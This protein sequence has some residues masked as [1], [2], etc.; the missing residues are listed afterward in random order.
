MAKR[1]QKHGEHENS[2]RWLLTY[3]DMITLLMAFFIMLYSM[4]QLDLRKFAAVAGSVRAEL[5]GTGVME[6]GQGVG[7]GSG[8]GIDMGM[9]GIAP[10]LGP[11]PATALKTSVAA[12]MK[13]IAASRVQ[14]I[15]EGDVVRVRMPAGSLYFDKGGAEL[16]PLA[17]R[18]LL[19]V[20]H[21]LRDKP[22]G[23]RAEGHTCNLPTHSKQYS[24][25]WELS[26][27][28]ASNTVLFLV[29]EGGL[30]S[31]HCSFMGFADRRPLVANSCE[32]NRQRNR[33]VELIL[34]PMAGKKDEPP[35]SKPAEKTG[36]VSALP[37]PID[38]TQQSGEVAP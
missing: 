33:R 37:P 30:S 35:A 27:A 34:Q 19:G 38:I 3:A 16:T 28:R 6:G 25:N 20:A 10:A 31:D 36:G 26:A 18:V 21:A 1:K 29:R 15:E 8:S 5:G 14:V 12:E 2:E 23:V 7:D 22:S 13:A 32:R 24:S 4:S 17:R 9:G 11:S